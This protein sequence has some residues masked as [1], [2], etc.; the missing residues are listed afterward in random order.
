[1]NVMDFKSSKFI[2]CICGIVIL[3]VIAES[4]FFIIRAWREGRRI[5][6]TKDQ[7]SGTVIQSALFS[8]APA[9]SIVAAI[10][11]LSG[12]LGLALPWFRLSVIGAIQYELPAAES[13]LQAIGLSG[14][15]QEV[16]DPEAFSA[17]AWVMTLGSVDAL[18]LIPFI[19]KK[20]HK[21]VGQVATNNS[22]IA[23]V[24]A[25]SAMI[26]LICAF[27]V[28][29]L[30]AVGD[31]AVKG[32]GG[33]LMAL[34][35][36]LVSM[37]TMYLLTK[38][39]NKMQWTWFEPFLMPLSMFLAMGAAILMVQVLPESVAWLEWRG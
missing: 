15:S 5:G 38:F 3:F 24:I 18:V 29:S 34:V 30:L 27:I 23:N 32:D 37:L 13:A 31:P 4:L 7:L 17:V 39:N 2:Y 8:I 36:V 9:L 10:L 28:R 21:K 35:A 1:M 22:T 25:D 11:T 6:M 33:G 14:L 20:I 19:L 12:A 26:G 16:T